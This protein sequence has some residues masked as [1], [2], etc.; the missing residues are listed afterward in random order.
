MATHSV[1]AIDKGRG[2]RF[3]NQPN[4]WPQVHATGS[5]AADVLRQAEDAVA[6]SAAQVSKDHQPRDLFGIRRG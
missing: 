5:D 6:V 3:V 1:V 2:V 4:C